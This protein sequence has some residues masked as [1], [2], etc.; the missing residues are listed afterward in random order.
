M[1][2]VFK[3]AAAGIAAAAA[4]ARQ[5]A[6]PV[7]FYP[8]LQGPPL[9]STHSH[10]CRACAILGLSRNSP[11]PQKRTGIRPCFGSSRKPD[12]FYQIVHKMPA[13]LSAVQRT[14]PAAEVCALF[15]GDLCAAA[16]RPYI[17]FMSD[18]GRNW[19]NL[20]EFVEGYSNRPDFMVR[21]L[22]WEELPMKSGQEQ[23]IFL[24]QLYRAHFHELE[25]H[26]YGFLGRWD[27]ANIAAQDAFHTAWIRIEAVMASPNPVGWM[28]NTVR[29]TCYN[30]VRSQNRYL[31]LFLS[32]EALPP[33]AEPSSTDYSQSSDLLQEIED[34]LSPQEYALLKAIFI[35][36]RSYLDLAE[37][38]GISMWACRKRVERIIKK[39]RRKNNLE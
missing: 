21:W 19:T 25:V 11:A 27:L 5:P 26:A 16:L 7:L 6:P 24:E 12:M 30:M 17:L 9:H 39:I 23:D 36:G 13:L 35:D 32:L 2:Q 37:K 15:W 34:S 8:E 1:Q 20:E 3:S 28:K 29:N 38:L 4:P 14:L 33:D 31:K 10:L 22:S 18:Q